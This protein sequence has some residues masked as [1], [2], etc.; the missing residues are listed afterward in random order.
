MAYLKLQEKVL[1]S[2]N[3]DYFICWSEISYLNFERMSFIM[4][5]LNKNNKKFGNKNYSV[6]EELKSKIIEIGKE[7]NKE[8]GLRAMM[9]VYCIMLIFMSTKDTRVEDVQLFWDG[10]GQWEY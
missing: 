4:D 7:I 10:I 6:S 2:K 3:Q 1:S 5:E 8:G 9:A